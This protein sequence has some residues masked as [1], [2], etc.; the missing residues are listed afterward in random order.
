MKKCVLKMPAQVPEPG[1]RRFGCFSAASWKPSPQPV[2][3]GAQREI[4][5]EP[6]VRRLHRLHDHLAHVVFEHRRRRGRAQDA[7]LP[8]HAVVEQ[9]AQEQ[10]VVAG[11]AVQAAVALHSGR[12]AWPASAVLRTCRRRRACS[13]RRPADTSPVGTR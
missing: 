9:H 4:L 11:G 12:A 13:P 7:S 2:L 3:A 5:R 8:Q 6:L 1:V 10:A